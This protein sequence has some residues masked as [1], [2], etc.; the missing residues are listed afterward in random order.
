[1]ASVRIIQGPRLEGHGL[2]S[3]FGFMVHTT[4][5]G[6]PSEAA[7]QNIDPLDVAIAKYK[8]MTEGPHFVIGPEGLIVQVRQLTEVAYHVGV[9][10]DERRD[11]LSGAWTSRGDLKVGVARWWRARWP[12]VRSPQHLYPT[13]RP[14]HAYIGIENVPAGTGSPWVQRWGQGL[15]GRFTPA[16]YLANAALVFKLAPDFGVDVHKAGRVVG[17]EDINPLTRPGWDPGDM[18]GAWSWDLFWGLYAA[19]E[20]GIV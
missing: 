15:V 7:A 3:P 1:M 18:T 5:D 13:E 4:G 16:Q 17:H 6:P 10:A 9:H 20:K 8:A 2:L 19:L 14:N 12:N 11:F